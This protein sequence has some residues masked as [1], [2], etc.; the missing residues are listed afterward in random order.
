MP[1]LPGFVRSEF[2][3]DFGDITFELPIKYQPIKLIGQGT[4]G[5]VIS[6]QNTETGE[7]FAIKKI[8]SIED[9]VSNHS[10]IFVCKSVGNQVDAKRVL[11][12]IIIMKNVVHEN[13]LGLMDVV[14]VPRDG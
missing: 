13:L 1:I 5:A 12:E 6:A 2:R 9:T 10:M 8:S 11:R 3:S 14:Y 7:Q 4:Y